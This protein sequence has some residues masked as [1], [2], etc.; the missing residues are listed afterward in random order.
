MDLGWDKEQFLS[1]LCRQKAGLPA[2]A[3]EDEQAEI[4]IFTV[5]KIVEA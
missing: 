4:H 3:W 1:E 5:Q 2:R